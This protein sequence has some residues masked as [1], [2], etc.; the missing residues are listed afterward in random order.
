MAQL[1]EKKSFDFCKLSIC[2]NNSVKVLIVFMFVE[3]LLL[4]IVEMKMM[5]SAK[6]EIGVDLL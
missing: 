6:N 2:P 1:A 3:Q 4:C 5:S